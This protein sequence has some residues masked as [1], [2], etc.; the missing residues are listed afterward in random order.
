MVRQLTEIDASVPVWVLSPTRSLS[1]KQAC[2]LVAAIALASFAIGFFF[3][4]M[5]Y[6]LVLPFSGLEALAVAAAFYVVLRDGQNREVVRITDERLV[7]EKG[8]QMPEQSFEFSRYWVRVE[9]RP[10]RF[11]MHPRQLVVGAEGRMV[12]LGRFLTDGERESFAK[13]LINALKK[14]R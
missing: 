4:F 3:L 14:N 11:R 6:P 9:L 7:I 2:Q 13:T 12:E 1:W 8:N 5:G 10:A